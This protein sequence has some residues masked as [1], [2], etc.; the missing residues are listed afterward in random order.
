M[1][2]ER[3]EAVM[4]HLD[5][6]FSVGVVAGLTDGQL[7]EQFTCRRGEAAETAFA[8]L[9]ERHGPMVLRACQGIVGNDDD[10]QDAF[11]ATFLILARK[12]G[13]LWVQD[14][15]GPWL[16]R[17]ACRAALRVKVAADRRRA[18]EWRAAR[19]AV[20]RAGPARPSDLSHAL[21]EEVDRL[22][23]RYRLP[24]VLCDLEGCSYE[25]TARHLRC[26]VGTV[27]S[28]LARGRERLRRRLVRRGL[29]PAVELPGTAVMPALS[30]KAVPPAVLRSTIQGV[31]RDQSRGLAAAGAVSITAIAEGVLKAMFL[32]TIKR[33]TALALAAGLTVTGMALLARRPADAAPAAGQQ[34][35]Q[36][37][38][39]ITVT[40]P[41]LGAT[42]AESRRIEAPALQGGAK[43]TTAGWVTGVVPAGGKKAW[44]YNPETGT[45]HTYEAPKG[46]RI[47]SYDSRSD[48]LVLSVTADA[49][50]PVTELAVFST[51]GGKWIRHA[52]SDPTKMGAHPLIGK[53]LAVYL[54]GRHAYAFS[55]LTG[56]WSHQVLSEP[57]PELL[58]NGRIPRERQPIVSDDFLAY[59]DGRGAYCFSAV[60]GTWDTLT[61]GEGVSV[62]S[63]PGPT[64]SA[65]VVKGDRLFSF[66]LQAGRLREVEAKEE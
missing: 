22:P 40:P 42:P 39:E 4:R 5:V 3:S 23:E 8:A 7:L 63:T 56:T 6:L 21:H 46:I 13:T 24:V 14:S 52:L 32:T 16:H 15:L 62:W 33:T 65:L 61:V 64:G 36:T 57:A 50:E 26:P 9:V 55:A 58:Y 2:N 59:T 60:T 47:T 29:A 11:Q 17:V 18:A 49:G 25:E 53:H 48:F 44:A 38:V 1:T 30:L 37:K 45:W 34:A 35:G 28:R 66:D 10:A 31:L 41:V 19:H 54:I 51:K 43:R 20:N 12:S 27:K